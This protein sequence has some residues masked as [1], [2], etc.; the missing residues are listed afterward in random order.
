MGF[1]FGK[2][3]R[4]G[5]HVRLNIS[6]SG[7]GVSAGVKGMRIG[8]G[9]RGTQVTASIPGT[10]LSYSQQVGT[11]PRA[12]TQ[13]ASKAAPPTMLPP[14][15]RVPLFAPRHEKELVKGL[16]EYMAGREDTALHHFLAA[17]SKE[18]G[19]AIFA[20]FIL[21]QREGGES[22]ATA[23]LEEIVQGDKEFPTPVMRKYSACMH[24]QLGITPDVIAVMPVDGLAA[25]LLLAALYQNQGRVKEAIGLLEEVEELAGEPSVTLCLC[26]LYATQELWDGII[27]RAE[28][29]KAEDDVTLAIVILYGRAMQGKDLHEAAVSVFTEALR[30]KKNRSP[31]LLHEAMYWR[32]VSYQEL[33]RKSR[34]NKEFQRLYAEAPDFRD[35]AER[36]A[37]S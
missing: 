22:Q 19:A 6:K 12:A 5:K 7:V 18:A 2:S 33:G 17:A 27:E 8:T 24:L 37:A 35:V 21:G 13:R 23:L 29:T 36:V 10:G 30:R 20:A 16:N 31:K 26:E 1:R 15:L 11:G 4:I 28:Q 32:A 14:R 34:A 3:I 25:T 9:P